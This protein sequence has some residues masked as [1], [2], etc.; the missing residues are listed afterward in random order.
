MSLVLSNVPAE[1]AILAGLCQYNGDAYFEISDIINP[2]ND[3]Y[4]PGLSAE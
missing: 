2:N 3:N 1:R 4:L